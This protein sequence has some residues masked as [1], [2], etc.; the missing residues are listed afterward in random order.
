[1]RL[2]NR[3]PRRHQPGQSMVEFI[4]VTPV[5]FLLV[6]GA[7]QFALLYQAKTTLNYATFE[8]ARAM[9]AMYMDISEDPGVDRTAAARDLVRAEITGSDTEPAFAEFQLINP[10]DDS[11]RDHGIDVDGTCQIPSDNLMYRDAAVKGASQQTV[12]DANLLKLRVVYC[13]PLH[14]PFIDRM[15]TTILTQLPDDMCPHCIGT[16]GSGDSIE[17]TCLTNNRFPL[18]AQAIVRLQ[19]PATRQG[20]CP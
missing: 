15:L 12:Q 14:V 20:A 11:F 7:I 9:A 13:Y 8:A 5:M 18:N 10:S 1:M 3:F 4:I 16:Y 17:R 19:S 6:F 2:H